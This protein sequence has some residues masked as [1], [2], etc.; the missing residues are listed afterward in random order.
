MKSMPGRVLTSTA[1]S[2]QKPSK[3]ILVSA[4]DVCSAGP[5]YGQEPKKGGKV[6]RNE[7]GKGVRHQIKQDY[8]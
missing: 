1:N 5:E 2:K 3:Q 7:T 6:V 8:D 4:S